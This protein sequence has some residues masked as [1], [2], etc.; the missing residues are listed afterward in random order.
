MTGQSIIK[1]FGHCSPIAYDNFKR[2]GTC[3]SLTLL[4]NIADVINKSKGKTIIKISSN[5]NDMKQQ[6]NKFYGTSDILEWNVADSKLEKKIHAL[7]RPVMPGSW[8]SN[9]REWLSNVDIQNVMSQY[10]TKYTDFKFLGVFSVDFYTEKICSFYSIC[11]FNLFDFLASGKTKLGLIANLDSYYGKGSHWVAIS[12]NF[13]PKSKQF[14]IC[15]YDSGGSTPPEQLKLFIS[16]IKN[17]ASVFFKD[18][19]DNGKFKLHT[20]TKDSQKNT[21]DKKFKVQSNVKQHQKKNTECGIF[22]ML[23]IIL[24]LERQNLSYNDIC[25]ILHVGSDDF[26]HAYRQHLFYDKY[27]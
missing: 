19:F 4:A 5:V 27:A 7:Y 17:D 26:V 15:Y 18:R 8:K 23:F 16:Q 3:I 22:S 21:F 12:A 9:P 6:L 13:K 25:N 14:G 10:S 24:C 2:N 11:N 1:T 20:N